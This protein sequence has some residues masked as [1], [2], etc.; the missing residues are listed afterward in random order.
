MTGFLQ[1]RRVSFTR[2]ASDG[3]IRYKLNASPDLPEGWRDGSTVAIGRAKEADDSDSLHLGHPLVQAAVE[4][5]RAATANS[6]R[7]AWKVGKGAPAQL[8]LSK[9]KR[10][11]LA[12]NRVRY[13]RFE[14]VDRLIPAAVMEGSETP[15]DEQCARWLLERTPHDR[16]NYETDTAPPLDMDAA[17]ED[18]IDAMIFQDQAEVTAYEQQRFE[19]NLE[20]ID[21][22]VEDQLLVLKRRLNVESESLRVA[23]QRRDAALGSEART[24]AEERIRKL[25]TEIDRIEA[26]MQ[27]LENRDDQNYEK[28]R[29]R[30]H[31]RRY[32]PPEITRLLDVEFVL[33]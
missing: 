3:H 27:R 12:L 25:Q 1:A 5:A 2:S 4:E 14:R 24:Q 23:E 10:G 8:K 28:W 13:D 17:I 19:R 33:E 22:Y 21:R 16:Q 32:R 18:A 11:R 9:G 6:V 26:E 20:Q 30:A 31:Q 7:V 15:L 29:E